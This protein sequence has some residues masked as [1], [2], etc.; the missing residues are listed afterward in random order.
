M[1]TNFYTY[2]WLREDGTPYYVGKGKGLRAFQRGTHLVSPP[3]DP[4]RIILQEWD[5]EEQAFEAE[6]FLILMYGRLDLGT[7][8]LR[9]LAD[10]GFLSNGNKG[11]KLRPEWKAKISQSLIGNSRTLGYKHTKEV[12]QKKATLNRLTGNRPSFKGHQH[13]EEFKLALAERN[14]KRV[15]TPAMRLKASIGAQTR[16][17]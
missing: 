11:K 6:V 10:G 15:W 3:T 1:T 5:T 8:C 12:R 4:E 2:L 14:R 7:G 16:G 9:N 13:T 17:Q